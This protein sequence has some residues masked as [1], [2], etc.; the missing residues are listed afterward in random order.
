MDVVRVHDIL[1][2]GKMLQFYIIEGHFM[3]EWPKKYAL[4]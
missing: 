3:V 4:S 2:Q 1:I